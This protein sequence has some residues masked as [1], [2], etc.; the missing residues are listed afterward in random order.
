M[1]LKPE[2]KEVAIKEMAK[3][4]ASFS[5]HLRNPF[6][7]ECER[8]TIRIERFGGKTRFLQMLALIGDCPLVDISCCA[9]L[10]GVVYMGRDGQHLWNEARWEKEIRAIT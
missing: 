6:T 4:G 9:D 3:A 5:R 10:D 8:V 2:F 1:F 7:K